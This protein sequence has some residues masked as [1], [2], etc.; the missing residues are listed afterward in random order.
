MTKNKISTAIQ[1][2]LFISECSGIKSTL[3]I[4]KLILLSWFWVS[5]VDVGCGGSKKT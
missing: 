5:Q 4:S 1:I 3:N 2:Q